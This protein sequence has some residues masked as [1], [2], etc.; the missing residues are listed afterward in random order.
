MKIFFTLLLSFFVFQGFAQHNEKPIILPSVLIDGRFY[1]KI[2]TATSDTVLGLC[3]S[4]GGFN[5]IYPSVLKKLN[6]DSKIKVV[7]MDGE[8]LSYI[9]FKDVATALIPAPQIPSAFKNHIDTPFLAVPKENME[10]KMMMK[11]VP[12][13]V[14]LGQFFFLGKA[15][16]FDY[17]KGIISLNTPLK[18]NAKNVQQL[19]FKKDDKGTK[20]FG[21]PSMKV[22]IDGQV[23]D[24]LFDTGASILLSKKAQDSLQVKS[25]SMGGSFIARSIFN[26]W[27]KKHPEWRYIKNGEVM[28]SDMIQVPQVK[29]GNTTAGPVW[30]AARPDEAWSQG[31]IATMDKV[32]KGAVG[33]SLFQYYK[34]TIDYNAELVSFQKSK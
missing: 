13:D 6:L 17:K 8:Q 33:G 15:W 20:L 25:M 18:N 2:P 26:D 28:G 31:M 19:G 9:L 16:T 1:I 23:I 29:V 7:D 27:R 21:H 22:E 34:V 14:F 3:D 12:H 5:A 11:F 4:G 24:V 32:V 10:L 30:F